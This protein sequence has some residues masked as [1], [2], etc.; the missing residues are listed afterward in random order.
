MTRAKKRKNLGQRLIVL[1]LT[2]ILN[3][4]MAFP[5][6]AVN[7]PYAALKVKTQQ[8]VDAAIRSGI[9]PEGKTIYDCSYSTGDD[10]ILRVVAYVDDD[11][12]WIDVTT[13]KELV[14]QAHV[15]NHS[16][17]TP[18]VEM[19][20]EE[21]LEKYADEVFR[22][23]NEARDKAG[24]EPLERDSLLDEAAM[25]RAAEVHIVDEA[26]GEPHTRPDGTRWRTVLEDMGIDG[27]RCAENLNRSKA[28]PERA[29]E[30]WMNSDG[31]REA[32]LRERYGTI[33]I[34]VFQRSDGK[35]DW[36]QIFERK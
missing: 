10:G 4:G 5:S 15:A 12:K 31:H 34:G 11:G 33:G 29:M 25:I 16:G 23:V 19:L 2:I 28:T 1:I 13:G 22:L 20:S 32:I 7:D 3:V 35:L 18:S 30:S 8:A 27:D 24:V 14:A 36:I 21:T 9:V 26:G 6:Y 17:G